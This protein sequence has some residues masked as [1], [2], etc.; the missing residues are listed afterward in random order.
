M[1][2]VITIIAVVAL[3]INAIGYGLLWAIRAIQE[4][5]NDKQ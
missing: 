1:I 4:Y 5:K 2:T 3:A